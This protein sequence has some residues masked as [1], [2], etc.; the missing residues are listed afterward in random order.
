MIAR[1]WQWFTEDC[2]DIVI[3]APVWAL[4]DNGSVHTANGQDVEWVFGGR[5][6]QVPLNY[7]SEDDEDHFEIVAD[8]D[9]PDEVWAA[10]A[11]WRLTSN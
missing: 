8:E 7:V 5:L 10:L 6:N 9:V 2:D 3:E 4:L 11:K 1:I